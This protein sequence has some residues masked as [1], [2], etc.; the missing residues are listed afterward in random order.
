VFSQAYNS[1]DTGL[2]FQQHNSQGLENDGVS[3]SLA[4]YVFETAKEYTPEFGVK[5]IYRLDRF[6]RGGDQT[7]FY[8]RGYAAIRFTE[9]NENFDHQHQDV[10]VDSGKQFGDLPEFMNFPYCANVA[11]VNAAGIASLALAP[12]PPANVGI[13]TSGLSYD[14]KLQWKKNTEPDLSG[15]YV[16]YRE[17]T[18]PVWEHSV[19]TA[20]TTVTLHVSKDDYLFA[21]QAVDKE[22]NVSLPVVP[23]PVR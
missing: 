13:V 7:P 10:R 12:A 2:V 17:T 8:Q 15:Y 18:S 23:K 20:D 19:F 5:M 22:G 16:R 21:V 11:R 14:T 4:R 1:T 9:A 3:R 6:L